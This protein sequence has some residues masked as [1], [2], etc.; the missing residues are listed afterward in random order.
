VKA[1]R[2]RHERLRKAAMDRHAHN[3]DM[4]PLEYIPACSCAFCLRAGI[5]DVPANLQPLPK[6]REPTHLR[7][8]NNCNCVCMVCASCVDDA[9]YFNVVAS[10]SALIESTRTD[11]QTFGYNIA[12][13][14]CLYCC[15]E[16]DFQER[17]RQ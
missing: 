6:A 17:I 10:H 7:R 13:C 15:A 14:D 2:D 16:R 12:D 9:V 11:A 1:H 5:S 8:S 3:A 4:Y